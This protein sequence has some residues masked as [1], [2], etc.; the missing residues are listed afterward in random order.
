[1]KKKIAIWC[2]LAVVLATLISFLPILITNL[3]IQYLAYDKDAV[4]SAIMKIV[5]LGIS[6]LCV[7]TV[8]IVLFFIKDRTLDEIKLNMDLLK[9]KRNKRIQ[10]Q[11][12]VKKEQQLKKLENKIK[13]LKED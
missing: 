11:K 13:E 12:R 10:E 8:A 4:N 9:E 2:C 5:F 1:M 7:L 6:V 3:E